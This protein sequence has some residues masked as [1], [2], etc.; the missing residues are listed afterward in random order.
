MEEFTSI[1]YEI[2]VKQ[3]FIKYLHHFRFKQLGQVLQ[4]V[5]KMLQALNRKL[6]GFLKLP[7]LIN[8]LLLNRKWLRL[9]F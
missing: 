1:S 5:L 4:Q 7:D 9:S 3:I 8:S 6:L 2:F